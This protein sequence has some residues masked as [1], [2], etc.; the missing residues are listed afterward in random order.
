VHDSER[1]SKIELG[2]SEE[3]PT[4]SG[5]GGKAQTLAFQGAKIGIPSGN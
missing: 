3:M 4:T 5:C 1:K 2:F